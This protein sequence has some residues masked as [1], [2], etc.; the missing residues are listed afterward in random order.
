M[1]CAHVAHGA[2][3]YKGVSN[4]HLI[5]EPA[6]TASSQQHPER[7]CLVQSPNKPQRTSTAWNSIVAPALTMLPTPQSST[8]AASISVRRIC[9]HTEPYCQRKGVPINGTAR[10]RPVLP[11]GYL[12]VW[13]QH[14]WQANQ[15]GFHPPQT[16]SHVPSPTTWYVWFTTVPPALSQGLP[17]QLSHTEQ[18]SHV[19]HPGHQLS[20]AEWQPFQAQ[21]SHVGHQLFFHTEASHFTQGTSHLPS[22]PPNQ[23]HLCH[24]TFGSNFPVTT[25]S[26]NRTI[27]PEEP[28]RNS[29][30]TSDMLLNA[31]L[32]N[33]THI[34][35]RIKTAVTPLIKASPTS[36]S[37]YRPPA[38]LVSNPFTKLKADVCSASYRGNSKGPS[39]LRPALLASQHLH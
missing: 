6:T 25:V 35:G 28:P 31:G 7:G 33:R 22:L 13:I 4:P 8:F 27:S 38:I 32:C 5:R 1:T 12:S 24:N 37:V 39:A 29:L 9:F 17:P 23:G 21:F 30:Q 14:N 10:S 19:G 16:L 34:M 18:H 20:H 36:K 15:N 11:H 3:A 2:P 26:A